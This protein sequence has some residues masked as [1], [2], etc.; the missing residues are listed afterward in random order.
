MRGL[1]LQG[2]VQQQQDRTGYVTWQC[3]SVIA[4]V[5]RAG[6][7]LC[8]VMHA[9]TLLTSTAANRLLTGTAAQ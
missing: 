6:L 2:K 8:G 1:L 9:H 4:R 3:V 7:L 5:P